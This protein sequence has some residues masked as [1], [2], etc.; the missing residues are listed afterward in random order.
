[1]AAAQ[2]VG[3]VLG[4][5]VSGWRVSD[6]WIGA[7][8]RLLWVILAVAQTCRIAPWGDARLAIITD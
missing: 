7:R 4:A 1:M 8:A 5:R 2:G 6:G 3:K